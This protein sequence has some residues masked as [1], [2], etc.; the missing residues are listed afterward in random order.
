VNGED[1]N[2][3]RAALKWQA[4]ERFSVDT[5][6]YTSM[7]RN[8]SQVVAPS[9]IFS[10]AANG[11]KAGPTTTFSTPAMCIDQRS[12]ANYV[13]Y[14]PG[15]PIGQP[16][17]ASPFAPVGCNTP[18]VGTG[19]TANGGFGGVPGAPA[20][21]GY[22]PTPLASQYNRPG[23]TYGPFKQGPDI[24]YLTGQQELS[25][26]ATLLDVVNVALNYDFDKINVKSITSFIPDTT[27]SENNGGEDQTQ[28]QTIVGSPGYN[29]AGT[30]ANGNQPTGVVGFPL[31]AGYPDYPGHFV[32]L[33]NRDG[34][35]EEFRVSSRD[36]T[37]RLSWV[38]GVYYE[39]Q[40]ITNLYR[41][42]DSHFN[43]SLQSFWGPAI[44]VEQRYGVS[45]WDGNSA[46]TLNAHLVDQ[47]LA[48]YAEG[49]YYLFSK[50]K[51]TAGVRVS[52][53]DFHFDS[54]DAG[55]F[56]S[57]YPNSFGGGEIGQE[58]DTPVTP[59]FGITYEFTKADLVYF[60]AAKGFRSGG[61][62]APVGPVVCAPGLALYGITAT[63]APLTYAPDTVWSYEVGGKFRLLDN[64]MQLNAAAYR[65]DWSGIQSA[66]TLTC[67]QGFV[68]NGKGARSQGFDFQGQYRPI[69]PLTLSLNV[70]YDNAYYIDPVAGPLG[71]GHGPNAVNAGDPFPVAPWQISATAAYERELFNKWDSYIQFDYQWSS[72]YHTPGSFGVASWNPYVRDVGAVDNVS[73]RLGVKFGTWDLNVFSNNLLDRLEKLGNAG[74]GITQCIATNLACTNNSNGGAP[75][76]GN[77][78]PFV[79]QLYTRPREIGLQANYRF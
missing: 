16:L 76:Y 1:Q 55:P 17:G 24:A 79:S 20:A 19:P 44:G 39:Y 29:A 34:L 58:K 68:E 78:N 14:Q 62:N 25:S 48:G 70:G 67:G 75:G 77:L 73:A 11:T 31:W 18:I 72:G 15:L 32:G 60:T 5:S 59:K 54:F 41:Y 49:N 74:N 23:Y 51:L 30:P 8:A 47:N 46:T 9:T 3:F 4:T 35:E 57:R 38:A 45:E 65:V 50:L 40:K 63:Q 2:M 6:F 43:A 71:P 42:P 52:S 7:D 56:S 61:V 33:S 53:L 12:A 69:D 66:I 64:R 13:P 37:S 28:R 10:P 26:R 27:Y 22:G 36:P 21:G